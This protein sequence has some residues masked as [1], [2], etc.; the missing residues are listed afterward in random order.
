MTPLIKEFVALADDPEQLMWFDIGQA[1]EES[2][3]FQVDG[4]HLTHLPFQRMAVCGVDAEKH[5][6]MLLLIGGDGHV[7]VTGVTL[8]TNGKY[9]SIYPFAYVDTPEGVRLL[10]PEEGA[11]FPMRPNGARPMDKSGCMA[12]MSIVG[13]MLD[14]LDSGGN[15]Y[16]PAVKANSPTNKRRIAN[17]K[18]ALI[19]DWRT[20]VVEP[21]KTKSESLGGTHASPRQHERRGHWRVTSA[22]RKV[23]VRNCTVGDASKGTVFHDYKVAE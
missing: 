17:G 3:D 14:S 13:Y 4:E 2:F 9:E 23:W 10:L 15:V 1:P 18:P 22:G 7:S 5:K 11:R 6:F 19:Y 21:K 12:A 16:Q 20:V 8:W